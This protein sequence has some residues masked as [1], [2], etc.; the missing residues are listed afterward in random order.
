MSAQKTIVSAPVFS[1]KSASFPHFAEDALTQTLIRKITDDPIPDD[2]TLRRLCMLL[3][4]GTENIAVLDLDR[5]RRITRVISVP[6][7]IRHGLKDS[8][9]VRS[10]LGSDTPA[11]RAAAI[12]AVRTD[13]ESLI[14]YSDILDRFREL[15]EGIPTLTVLCHGYRMLP[16]PEIF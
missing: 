7:C 11:Y 13:E 16:L 5:H 14:L 15:S 4:H 3:L 2:H 9:Y 1:R 10:V 12:E 6:L 8:Y